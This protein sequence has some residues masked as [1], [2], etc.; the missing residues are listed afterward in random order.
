M[1]DY[2]PAW[3]WLATRISPSLI[4]IAK[5]FVANSVKRYQE[6]GYIGTTEEEQLKY[7]CRMFETSLDEIL[8]TEEDR[9]IS[10]V[11]MLYDRVRDPDLLK[12]LAMVEA[13]IWDSVP[14][15]YFDR[16]NPIDVECMFD[17]TKLG[18]LDDD[19]RISNPIVKDFALLH[20]KCVWGEGPYDASK[21]PFRRNK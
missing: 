21:D 20:G 19:D 10:F 7:L 2:T 1:T 6:A 9:N 4:P 5:A 3:D 13:G 12:A 11:S 8:P 16:K 14:E 17:L 15:C 18:L